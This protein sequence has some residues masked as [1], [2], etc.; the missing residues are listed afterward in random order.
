MRVLK[1]DIEWAGFALFLSHPS[2]NDRP[3]VKSE[4]LARARD[5]DRVYMPSGRALR[6]TG[7]QHSSLLAEFAGWMKEMIGLGKDIV[8]ELTV[9]QDD[10]NN[11]LALGKLKELGLDLYGEHASHVCFQGGPSFARAFEP[12]VLSS[13][14][15]PEGGEELAG[16]PAAAAAA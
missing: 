15:V 1:V 6:D 9:R 7:A 12:E 2:Y 16:G 8:I 13:C 3:D 4:V 14:I 5:E 10:E 11:A